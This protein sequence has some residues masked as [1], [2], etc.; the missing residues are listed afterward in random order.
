MSRLKTVII[1]FNIFLILLALSVSLSI[2]AQT[3]FSNNVAD[4]AIYLDEVTVKDYGLQTYHKKIK[5]QN[6]HWVFNVPKDTLQNYRDSTYF[7]TKFSKLDSVPVKIS[8]ITCRLKPFDTSLFTLQLVFFQAADEDSEL[9]IIP[10]NNPYDIHNKTLTV[11]LLS[12]HIHIAPKEFY[13]GYGFVTKNKEKEFSYRFYATTKGEGA[14]LYYKEG[15][16][17]LDP[18]VTSVFPF[19][20]AYLRL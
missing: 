17:F 3:F 15:K 9:H 5:S 2:D 20:I 8:K 16:F 14:L 4:T 6:I 18:A 1:T 11:N 12:E 10:I 19:Q 13:I 7:L